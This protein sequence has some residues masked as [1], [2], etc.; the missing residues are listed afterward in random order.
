LFWR[1]SG[2]STEQKTPGIPFRTIPQKRKMLGI[3]FHGTKKGSKLSE[4]SSELFRGRE[5][6]SEFLFVEQK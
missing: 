1:N 4:F 5:N 2:C 6:N 3:L